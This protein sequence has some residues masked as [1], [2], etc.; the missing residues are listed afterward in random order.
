MPCDSS[1]KTKLQDRARIIEALKGIGYTLLSSADDSLIVAE[2]GS[3]RIRFSEGRD[4]YFA[5][6]DTRDLGKVS[7]KYAEIG[8]RAWA[9]RAGYSITENDGT[10]MVLINRRK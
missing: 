8:V 6:G 7:K 5:S 10:N 2:M 9:K 4:G 1:I 3:R